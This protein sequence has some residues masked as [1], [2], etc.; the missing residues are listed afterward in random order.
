MF[1]GFLTFVEVSFVSA[2]N[3]DANP[4]AIGALLRVRGVV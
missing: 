1:P 4:H 3:F 2:V